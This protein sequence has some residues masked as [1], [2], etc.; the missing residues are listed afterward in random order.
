MHRM[1]TK[2]HGLI[3]YLTG[4][5]LTVVP[6]IMNCTGRTRALLRSC[7]AAAVAYSAVTNYERGLYKWLPMKAHLA[8]DALSGATLVTAAA[9]FD[10]ED[11]GV[12]TALLGIGL[13]EI[14]AAA[15]TEP[16]P[17]WEGA[18]SENVA[19]QTEPS[20]PQAPRVPVTGL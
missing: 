12:R 3:D 17:S 18:S 2:A 8:L 14:A 19:G 7:G 20:M 15:M 6:G 4:A 5:A 9:V 16:R 11:A 1:S 13:F 10:D